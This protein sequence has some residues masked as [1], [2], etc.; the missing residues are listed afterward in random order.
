MTVTVPPDVM[1]EAFWFGSQFSGR[2]KYMPW[3]KA[4][5]GT[6]SEFSSYNKFMA[7]KIIGRTTTVVTHDNFDLLQGII[8]Y[9]IDV[10]TPPINNPG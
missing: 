10:S 8:R 5:I 6:P 7:V 4:W 1:P 9:T 2:Y 3:E